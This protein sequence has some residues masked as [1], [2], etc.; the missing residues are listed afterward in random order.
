M[1]ESGVKRKFKALY[2]K[3]FIQH[4]E[5][6]TTGEGIPDTY[7]CD[8]GFIAWAEFKYVA[9]WPVRKGIL[10]IDH[11]TM[12]Q[13]LWLKNNIDNGGNSILILG[14]GTKEI[15]YFHQLDAL[16]VGTLTEK[17]LRK[18]DKGKL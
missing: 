14:V 10:R 7:I 2:N 15:L 13:R 16:V 9:R 4:I 17:D 11:Y 8:N 1:N 5:S 3:V 18:L 6:P 12:A